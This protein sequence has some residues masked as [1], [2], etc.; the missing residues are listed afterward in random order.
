MPAVAQAAMAHC[1]SAMALRAVW[2]SAND[3]WAEVARFTFYTLDETLLSRMLTEGGVHPRNRTRFYH[4]GARVL[5]K[6]KTLIYCELVDGPLTSTLHRRQREW[7]VICVSIGGRLFA[8]RSR[9]QE[10][11]AAPRRQPEPPPPSRAAL[12]R[13]AF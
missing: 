11:Q 3:A 12:E 7:G 6:C 5:I 13:P 10:S 4:S 9:P 1:S 8:L 2:F